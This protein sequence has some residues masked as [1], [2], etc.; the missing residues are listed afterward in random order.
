M[1]RMSRS[2]EL[3]KE[4]LSPRGGRNTGGL[5]EK[6]QGRSREGRSSTRGEEGGL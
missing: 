3:V 2:L 4:G 1:Q 6:S 5:L